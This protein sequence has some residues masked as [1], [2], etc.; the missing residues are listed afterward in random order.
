MFPALAGVAQ[1][2]QFQPVNQRV[3]SLIPNQ[4]HMPGWQAGSLVWGGHMRGN[5]T[6]MFLSLSPSLI[7]SLK[8]N[9]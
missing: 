7:L 5:H 3:T 1:W 6:L 8:V 9:K 2:I 4:G